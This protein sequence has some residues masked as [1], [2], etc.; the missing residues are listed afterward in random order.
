M[1]TTDP[2]PTI[3]DHIADLAR[4][5]FWIENLS[6]RVE[7]SLTPDDTWFRASIPYNGNEINGRWRFGSIVEAVEAA[8]GN[9]LREWTEYDQLL[10]GPKNNS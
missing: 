5:A 1:N 9:A 8:V 6:M 2:I 4:A 7:S 3:P 10:F